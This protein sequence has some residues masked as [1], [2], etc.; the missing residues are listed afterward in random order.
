VAHSS[1]FIPASANTKAKP[2][3][4]SVKK[5]IKGSRSLQLVLRCFELICSVGLLVLM[6]LIR[7]VAQTTGWIMRIVVSNI[8]LPDQLHTF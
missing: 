3:N 7:D 1:W 4:P 5:W 8:Y 2:M 6:I